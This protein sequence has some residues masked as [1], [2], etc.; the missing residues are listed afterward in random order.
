MADTLPNSP[1]R[2]L[3]AMVITQA[4]ADIRAGGDLA[5]KV[6][7]WIGSRDFVTVCERAG[8]E[9]DQVATYLQRG[10]RNG[11]QYRDARKAA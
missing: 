7:K 6:K 9:P 5:G 1:E 8:I 4:R 11:A 10:G 3:W 2:Q